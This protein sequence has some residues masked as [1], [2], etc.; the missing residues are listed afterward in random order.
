MSKEANF[1]FYGALPSF[2]P[3]R[4]CCGIV[5]NSVL[6]LLLTA[7][8]TLQ[9]IVFIVIFMHPELRNM[10]NLNP[11]LKQNQDILLLI[12]TAMS[13]IWLLTVLFSFVGFMKKITYSHLPL[14]ATEVI[15]CLVATALFAAFTWS[16][17]PSDYSK[18]PIGSSPKNRNFQ[19]FKL[20]FSLFMALFHVYY[21]YIVYCLWR[22][23]RKEQK[24][25]EFIRRQHMID[26][27]CEEML[28]E[29][30]ERNYQENRT[31]PMTGIY[32]QDRSISTYSES[33][34]SIS[35]CSAEIR[36]NEMYAAYLQDQRYF[37]TSN[38]GKR[39]Y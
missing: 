22:D 6:Y 16:I 26:E 10:L 31:F 2:K 25:E 1:S 13:S 33:E 20:I 30:D 3:T 23:G 14:I 17:S 12:L 37:D 21:T 9:L 39:N 27:V 34:C 29:E 5:E 4:H 38:Y 24:T 35:M 8:T 15:F 36:I 19:L 28:W 32:P 11:N 7:L 18:I